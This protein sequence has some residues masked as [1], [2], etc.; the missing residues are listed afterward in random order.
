MSILE[1]TSEVKDVNSKTPDTEGIEEHSKEVVH[2]TNTKK[3]T[4][5]NR[6]E[7]RVNDTLNDLRTLFGEISKSN[8]EDTVILK[9]IKELLVG[10]NTYEKSDKVS[11][12]SQQID[13]FKDKRVWVTRKTRMESETRM[14]NN[15]IFSL[16]VVNFYT[17]I[18]L[19]L[20]ILSLVMADEEMINRI[21]VL[22]LIAS[23][24]LFGISLF[25]SLYGY[26][27]KAIAYK[28]CYIDLTRIE[29]QCQDL[30]LENLD[31]SKRLIKFN[32]IKKDYNHIL[33][34]TDNHS[35]VDRLVY[36]KNNGKLNNLED[37][38]SYKKYKFRNKTVKISIFLIPF[39][40]I[41]LIFVWK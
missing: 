35:S 10:L 41:I 32:E 3:V 24:T 20:S 8:K 22:T 9:E 4:E 13:H 16:F 18:V 1:R 26:K 27:E 21:T 37:Q 17:L 38:A 36:L 5:D 31:F 39:I 7:Y 2:E 15:N 29:S 19:G 11:L 34:K 12:L 25:V 28:Q 33:E 14:N 30:L 6:I 40:T 23:V